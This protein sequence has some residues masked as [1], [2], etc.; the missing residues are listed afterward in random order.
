MSNPLDVAESFWNKVKE[1][2]KNGKIISI[3]KVKKEIY[4]NEDDLKKWC[5][6]NLPD[7][8][9]K[10]TTSILTTY[11][12]IVGWA[13]SKSA[14]YNQQ[15][16][17]TFLDADEADAWLVAYALEN[18]L[19]VVTN[20]VPA[21]FSKTSIKIPDVCLAFKVPYLNPMG[22]FREMGERY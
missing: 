13:V 9:F 1:L 8:F 12:Q 6:A 19:K 2:A 10:D 11:S 20:E 14:Q 4:S 3:D 18:N 7:N 15:A 17:N 5:E 16:L 21:P 22:M